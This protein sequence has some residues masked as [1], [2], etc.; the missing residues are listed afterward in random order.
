[1]LLAVYRLLCLKNRRMYDYYCRPTP[2]FSTKSSRSKVVAE[3]SY[4][5]LPVEILETRLPGSNVIVWLV[6]CPVL[7]NRPGGPYADSNGQAWP[8]NA[9]RFAVFCHAAVDI[10]LNKLGLDWQPDVVHCNDWQ[11]GLVPALLSLQPERPVTIFT[12][13]NLA[14]QGV[15]DKQTFDRFTSP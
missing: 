2:R 10:S 9:L 5:N 14:Y 4:Y 8:D 12:I 6:D 7:F 3:C 11:T 13:H 15:F 1:M